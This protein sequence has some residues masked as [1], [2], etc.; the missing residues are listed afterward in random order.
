MRFRDE[1]YCAIVTRWEN[2]AGDEGSTY[3]QSGEH[4]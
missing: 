1:A 2:R 4:E 3:Q